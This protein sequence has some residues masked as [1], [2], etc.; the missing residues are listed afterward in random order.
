LAW[1]G[2]LAHLSR[3]RWWTSP[4]GRRV[5]AGVEGRPGHEQGRRQ[6]ALGFHPLSTWRRFR[7]FGLHW[8]PCVLGRARACS[9]AGAAFK[10]AQRGWN[11]PPSRCRSRL[12]G[13]LL[14]LARGGS[15]SQRALGICAHTPVVRMFSKARRRSFACPSTRPICAIS[16][17]RAQ[18]RRRAFRLHRQAGRDLCW[19]LHR[20][21]SHWQRLLWTGTRSSRHLASQRR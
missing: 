5:T 12:G 3:Q 2:K 19:A 11:P 10:D 15:A 6:L 16:S 21:R 18:L 8:L 9:C 20:R 1:L 13:R 14:L 7:Q 17:P 4:V